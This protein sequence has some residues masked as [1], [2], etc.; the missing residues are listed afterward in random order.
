M[1]PDDLG[2]ADTDAPNVHI[3]WERTGRVVLLAL[4]VDGEPTPRFAFDVPSSSTPPADGEG[5]PKCL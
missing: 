5:G 4:Q 1:A 3:L 2:I